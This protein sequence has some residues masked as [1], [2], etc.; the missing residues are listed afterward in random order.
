[1]KFVQALFV[2]LAYGAFCGL[3]VWRH[4]QRVQAA[5]QRAQ[6]LL[7][8]AVPDSS[9]G[10]TLWWVVHASQTGQ[11]EALAEQT[12]QALHSAGLAVRLLPLGQL[13]RDDL[14]GMERLLCIVSTYGE[15]DAPDSAAAFVR[16]CMDDREAAQAQDTESLPRLDGLQVGLLALGDASYA[17]YCGFGRALDAWFQASGAQALFDRVEVDRMAPAAM[18]RWRKQLGALIGADR[19]GQTGD[20]A[21]AAD[22]PDWETPPLQAWTLR[23]RCHLNPG[24]AGGPVHHLEFV[25]E[26]GDLPAWEAGDLAQIDIPGAPGAPRDYSIASVP[27]DGALHLLVRQTWRVHADGGRSPGLASGWL[28]AATDGGL[29]LHGRALLRLR[30]HSAFRIG[31]NAQRPLI[32]IGNGTGLAGLRAHIRARLTQDPR[33]SPIQ[34]PGAS[35][36]WLIFG[37]RNA[38]TDAYYREELEA[39]VAQGLL[40]VDWVFS[41]DSSAAQ[42]GPRPYVQHALREAAAEVRGWVAGSQTRAGAAIYVCGSLQGMAGEV[43]AALR[44]ILGETDLRALA[45]AGRYRRDVY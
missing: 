5:A 34:A 25:P 38:A 20:E 13:R 10:R 8:S 6:A 3:I 7:H 42:A 12:A 22:L 1:M 21:G 4:R 32:L 35:T 2:L 23:A 44:D 24:S 11:A 27:A 28:T 9:A 18:L 37:E 14:R 33:A 26:A 43:D 19:A 36:L 17:Q 31:G 45:D 16:D 41:R 29:P 30:A 15:G 39:W 40:R